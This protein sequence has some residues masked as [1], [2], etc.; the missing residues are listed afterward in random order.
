MNNW[1][2]KSASCILLCLASTTAAVAQEPLGYIN[3]KPCNRFCREWSG[4]P[5]YRPPPAVTYLARPPAVVLMER[6]NRR[7]GAQR[8]VQLDPFE[9]ALSAIIGDE[10]RY[11]ELR[12]RAPRVGME[13]PANLR[14]DRLK[15][16]VRNTPPTRL[17]QTTPVAGALPKSSQP[18]Q[19]IFPLA[20]PTAAW[21]AQRR[22]ALSG[23]NATPRQND[24]SSP[25][26][27]AAAPVPHGEPDDAS[28]QTFS[29]Q[30]GQEND[31]H[32]A[33]ATTAIAP[34]SSAA[35]TWAPVENIMTDHQQQQHQSPLSQADKTIETTEIVRDLPRELP[36][37][38]RGAT[39]RIDPEIRTATIPSLDAKKSEQQLRLNEQ[40]A[41]PPKTPSLPTVESTSPTSSD[42]LVAIVM[43]SP[44][45]TSLRELNEKNIAIDA[46]EFSALENIRS[47]L[48]AL[49]AQ[50]VKISQGS[51]KA[52]FRLFDGEVA[53]AVV[54]LVPAG[55]AERFP[56]TNFGGYP[57]FKIPLSDDRQTVGQRS[58][59]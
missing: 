12:T 50:R 33:A 35:Q 24:Q 29:K 11:R 14:S 51:S 46:R 19:A 16:Q 32:S 45:I 41:A 17:K 31:R 8:I 53:A 22:A 39:D 47:S 25:K 36:I 1:P 38:D 56:S 54:E 9:S 42:R 37:G 55:A 10:R 30:K 27:T 49:G 26:R 5:P 13:S 3:G 28:S 48:A 59:E 2:S 23:V 57:M 4:L 21:A 20:N 58:V 18:K 34:A 15:R 43:A 6:P 44:Q 52:V 40:V 7:R